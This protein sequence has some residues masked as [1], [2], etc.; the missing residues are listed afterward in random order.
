MLCE[1]KADLECGAADPAGSRG[2]EG[3]GVGVPAGG[4][5]PGGVQRAAEGPAG[6]AACSPLRST[7]RAAHPGDLR[8]QARRRW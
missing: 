8:N 6:G 2:A 4:H 3:G 1:L 5:V 7:P